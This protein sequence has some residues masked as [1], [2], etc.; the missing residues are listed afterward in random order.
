[1][2]I[3]SKATLLT[4][5]AGRVCTVISSI[6]SRSRWWCGRGRS[7]RGEGEIR[8]GPSHS[9]SEAQPFPLLDLEISSSTS[10]FHHHDRLRQKAFRKTSLPPCR[11][12][13]VSACRSRLRVAFLQLSS[14]RPFSPPGQ[15]FFFELS[16]PA[17]AAPAAARTPMKNNI[18][19]LRG[20]TKL[21]SHINLDE[22]LFFYI[23]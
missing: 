17:P 13:V 20:L 22:Q 21:N 5:S 23:I 1:M 7:R 9:S 4:W 11:H 6:A 14:P 19:A 15:S 12:E 16:S 18:L 8:G 3:G 10:L 2:L